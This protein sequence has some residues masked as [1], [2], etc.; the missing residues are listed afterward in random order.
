MLQNVHP[1]KSDLL[2]GYTWS[3]GVGQEECINGMGEWVYLVRRS[4]YTWPGG[5][6][7][8]GQEELVYLV[9][10]GGSAGVGI[11]GQEDWARRSG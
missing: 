2:Y 6:G 11:L 9:R 1:A 7:I 4:G 5:V 3:G 10:M 8:L